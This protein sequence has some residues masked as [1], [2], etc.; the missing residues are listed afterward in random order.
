MEI[1]FDNPVYLWYLISLPLLVIT[2]FLSLKS[3]KRKAMKFANFKALKRIAG[4]KI[5]T[6]NLWVLILRLTIFC[7]LIFAAS[8]IHYSYQTERSDNNYVI[9]L[10]VSS[11]MSARDISPTRIEASKLHAKKFVDSLDSKTQVGIVTFSGVTLIEQI[12]T[13]EKDVIKEIIT[14]IEAVKAGGTDIPGAIITGTNMLLADPGRGRVIILI[15]D[16]SSTLGNFID[17]SMDQATSYAKDNYVTI[18]SLGIGSESGP[19]GYLPEYYNIS[20]TYNE[21]LLF[22]VANST[23]GVFAQAKNNEEIPA[24]INKLVESKND[25]FTTVRLD[26]G[27][28]IIGIL[29]L[30]VEWGLINSR[31]R[32]IT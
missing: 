25:S 32:R 16:G 14:D 21:E 9:A 22:S 4:K 2:H 3:A 5:I 29:L 11:S 15:T 17:R 6:R 28:L 1:M 18:H 23:G 13:D 20:A 10:D 30:F 19:I 27:S 24:A 26:L 7:F 12:M 8:G 31:Y